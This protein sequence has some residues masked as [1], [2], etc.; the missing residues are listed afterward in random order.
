MRRCV[1]T[2]WLSTAWK[3]C[4]SFQPSATA[5]VCIEETFAW[6]CQTGRQRDWKVGRHANNSA[7]A[8][9]ETKRPN[10]HLTSGAVYQ[11]IVIPHD[12]HHLRVSLWRDAATDIWTFTIS[13]ASLVAVFSFVA[14]FV[15]F[16]DSLYPVPLLFICL[17][18]YS[19]PPAHSQPTLQCGC[20]WH[21]TQQHTPLS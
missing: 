18:I 16:H 13:I 10:L 7:E 20:D 8:L 3:V 6:R 19:S 5:A 9:A 15:A 14:S 4:F 11:N 1:S 21:A 2:A 12:C 17:F